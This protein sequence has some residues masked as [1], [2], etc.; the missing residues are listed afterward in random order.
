MEL[1]RAPSLWGFPRA[2]AGLGQ[3]GHRVTFSWVPQSARGFGSRVTD[4]RRLGFS[5]FPAA[6]LCNV[7]LRCRARA[8]RPG[9]GGSLGE[10]DRAP[11]HTPGHGELGGGG[12]ASGASP[13]CLAGGDRGRWQEVAEAGSRTLRGPETVTQAAIMCLFLRIAKVGEDFSTGRI[14]QVSTEMFLKSFF[15]L[16]QNIEAELFPSGL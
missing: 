3:Q 15:V 8:D 13:G 2:A 7:C 5:A 16:S 4:S 1:G 10:C 6:S 9:A 14:M 11:P 12:G